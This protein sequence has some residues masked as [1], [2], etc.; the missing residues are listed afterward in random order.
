MVARRWFWKGWEQRVRCGDEDG[1]GDGDREERDSCWL[2][3]SLLPGVI[4]KYGQW[5]TGDTNH[6]ARLPGPCVSSD[7]S[8]CNTRHAQ[9]VIHS[10]FYVVKYIAYDEKE[11]RRVLRTTKQKGISGK[12]KFDKEERG[13]GCC[14][15]FRT[16]DLGR[17]E[18]E[19]TL[20]RKRN[21][22]RYKTC[23]PCAKTP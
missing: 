12:K 9:T 16:E 19:R 2:V 5:R 13:R 17:M 4:C 1:G 20:D 10:P 8:S 15:K 7:V 14:C 3:A 23:N 6:T 22:G 18:K 11:N 21:G